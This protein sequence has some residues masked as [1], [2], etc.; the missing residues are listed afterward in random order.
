VP[1]GVSNY[2]QKTMRRFGVASELLEKV[3][4]VQPD[5]VIR[6]VEHERSTIICISSENWKGRN[7]HNTMFTQNN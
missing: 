3:L 1:K 5:Q 2:L 4:R 7:L 6:L